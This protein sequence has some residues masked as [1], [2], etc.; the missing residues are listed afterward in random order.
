MF[1][2]FLLLAVRN[3]FKNST[4]SIINIFGISVGLASFI[5]LMLLVKYETSYDSFHNDHKR[6]YRVEQLVSLADDQDTW[7][8]LPAGVSV[9]L[10]NNYPEIE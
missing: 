9:E 5:M 4:Y 7:N 2:N 8:Q 10:E 6:I 1:K 3:F